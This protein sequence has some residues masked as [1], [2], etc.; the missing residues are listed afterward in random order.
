MIFLLP[1]AI[2]ISTPRIS[3]SPR[4]MRHRVENYIEFESPVTLSGS[5]YISY[6]DVNHAFRFLGL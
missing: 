4:D 2:R 3:A 6:Y 5:F 1:T